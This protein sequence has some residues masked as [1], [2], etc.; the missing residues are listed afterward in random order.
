MSKQWN[1]KAPPPIAI[2]KPL[3]ARRPR[4]VEQ[5]A[6]TPSLLGVD[7]QAM[8]QAAARAEEEA[9][10]LADAALERELEASVTSS[11]ASTAANRQTIIQ[12]MEDPL[13]GID[14]EGFVDTL[15]N[16]RMALEG[17]VFD[18]LRQ[19]LAM[20]EAIGIAAR[21]MQLL[22]PTQNIDI[23]VDAMKNR[24]HQAYT[25]KF[26]RWMCSKAEV[27]EQTTGLIIEH[28]AER[29]LK[30]EN[31][32]SINKK[33]SEPA[34]PNAKPILGLLQSFEKKITALSERMEAPQKPAK[35]AQ[36]FTRDPF[37]G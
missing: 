31:D 9:H 26:V 36:L 35:Q 24:V 11:E 5:A 13:T 4:V 2:N 34:D 29:L 12:E 19:E 30:P 17:D 8:L 32:P 3:Q 21:R 18:M 27:D 25:L 15:V 7:L 37:R 28:M 14:Q 1:R 6:V 20:H 33:K 23:A 10:M 22:L 16:E